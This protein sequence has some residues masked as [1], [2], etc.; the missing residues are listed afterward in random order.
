MRVCQFRHTCLCCFASFCS[1][2]K[3]IIPK[4]S[5]NVNHYFEKI[6]VTSLFPFSHALKRPQCSRQGLSGCP[7]LLLRKKNIDMKISLLGFA[8][9]AWRAGCLREDFPF[10]REGFPCRPEVFPYRRRSRRKRS[11][12][13][14]CRRMRCRRCTLHR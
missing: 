5:A 7:C 3:C 1:L 8:H 9:R 11:L 12:R 14:R 13:S 10:R 6:F 2:T 4:L